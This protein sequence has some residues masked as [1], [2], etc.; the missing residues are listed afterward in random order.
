MF[1]AY[2]AF[3]EHFNLTA[4]NPSVDT[5]CM[6]T[7]FLAR[8]FKSSKA[9][10]NYVSA[11]RLL[12]K[13]VGVQASSLHCFELDLMLR[14][15]SVTLDRTLPCRQPVSIGL[16][17]SLCQLCEKLDTLGTVVKCVFL[18]AFFGF[19]RISNVVPSAAAKFDRTRHLCG[20]DVFTTTTGLDIIIKWSK[21]RQTRFGGH[22]ITLPRLPGHP[23]CPVAAYRDMTR[24]VPTGANKPLFRFPGK[25]RQPL[26]GPILRAILHCLVESLGLAAG[27]ITFHSFRKGGASLCYNKGVQLA[28]IKQHGDWQSDSVWRYIFPVG[29]SHVAHAFKNI[30]L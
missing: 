5:I 23:L 10:V 11:V 12:H 15:M 9:I 26:T 28:H 4:I 6:Y 18:F 27:Q 7:E 20:G 24:V 14:A 1:K 13:L 16:L 25:S 8:S 30:L 3:C 2:L 21:T 17:S 22:T 19:L 29:S